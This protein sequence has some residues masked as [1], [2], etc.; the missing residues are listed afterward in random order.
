MGFRLTRPTPCEVRKQAFLSA[1]VCLPSALPLC[2]ASISVAI[3]LTVMRAL[4]KPDCLR[5]LST[6]VIEL[7]SLPPSV[8]ES[9]KRGLGIEGKG[10]G[11][12]A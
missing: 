6:L 5:A 7:V 3:V 9:I 4:H 12:V 1:T 2:P 10:G 11:D 8:G